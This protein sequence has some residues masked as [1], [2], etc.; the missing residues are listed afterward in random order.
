M[1][2]TIRLRRT[3]GGF[4]TVAE[5]SLRV[6]GVQ[7]VGAAGGA[8]LDGRT[9]A[10]VAGEVGVTVNSLADVDSGGS[11]V[12]PDETLYVDAAAAAVVAEALAVGHEALA[13]FAPG[14]T[15]VL[16][17]EHFDLSIPLDAVN[18]GVS[19]GDDHIPEPYAYVGPWDVSTL[20][21]A[22]WNTSFGAARPLTQLTDVRSFF[23]EGRT[24]SAHADHHGLG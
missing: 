7:L 14:V 17:P 12:S 1:S 11:G 15:A 13:A 10:E 4:G 21:G 3:P 16:W 8:D 20:S 24:L 5:P 9:P 19:P 22:F 23:E 2:G 6:S 18:Y